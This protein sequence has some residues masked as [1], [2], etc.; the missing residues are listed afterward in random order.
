MEWETEFL[1]SGSVLESV[2][3]LFSRRKRHPAKC[4]TLLTHL[5]AINGHLAVPRLEP[6]NQSPWSAEFTQTTLFPLI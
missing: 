5:L 4:G 2:L 3:T 1:N 6:K